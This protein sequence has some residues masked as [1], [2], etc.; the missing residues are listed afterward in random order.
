MVFIVGGASY[1]ELRVAYEV[2]KEYK[3]WEVIIGELFFYNVTLF[4]IFKSSADSL[5][6]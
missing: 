6:C 2:T 3:N 5:M 1:S 4:I